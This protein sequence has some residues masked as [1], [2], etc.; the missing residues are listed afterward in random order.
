M[1]R[2]PK[3]TRRFW[4]TKRR[5]IPA[6]DGMKYIGRNHPRLASGIWQKKIPQSRPWTWL[7]ARM[8]RA[9]GLLTPMKI[10]QCCVTSASISYGRRN[11]L[12]SAFMPNGSRR[13]GILPISSAFLMGFI[14]MRLPYQRLIS[15][16]FLT[17][18]AYPTA[19]YSVRD[20]IAE[21]DIEGSNSLP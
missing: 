3:A 7:S 10:W 6:A 21:S 9:F 17:W 13:D 18:M 4:G 12:V 20:V 2:M 16:D 1:A 19:E 11:P 5:E 14:K 15:I 8:N